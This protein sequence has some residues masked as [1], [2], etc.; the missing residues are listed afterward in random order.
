[1]L[2]TRSKRILFGWIASDIAWAVLFIDARKR[3]E[4]RLGLR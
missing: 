2:D 3:H 1:M 4:S